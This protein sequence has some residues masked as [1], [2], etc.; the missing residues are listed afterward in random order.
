VVDLRPGSGDA[1]R[2]GVAGFIAVVHHH[3]GS[4][5]SEERIAAAVAPDLRERQPQTVSEMIDV[6]VTVLVRKPQCGRN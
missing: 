5:V 1:E 6:A 3:R 2:V 4:E